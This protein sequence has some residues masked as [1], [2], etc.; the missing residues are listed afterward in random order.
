MNKSRLMLTTLAAVVL[1]I[2]CASAAQ[3]VSFRTHVSLTGNDANTATNC[4]RSNPCRNFAAAYSVTSPAGEIVAL[5]SAGF[6]GLTVTTAVT[7]MAIPG[8][9]GLTQVAAGTSGIAINAGAGDTVILKNLHFGGSLGANTIGVSH[10][11]GKL[12][13]ENCA[14]SQLTTGVQTASANGTSI[15][16][17]TFYG[18][19]NGLLGTVGKIDV[20]DSSFTGHTTRAV[21]ASGTGLITLTEVQVSNNNVGIEA[22][23]FGGCGS[24]NPVQPP[25]TGV[26]VDLGA[27]TN[28]ATAFLM[29]SQ[30]AVC[31][32]AP[33]SHGQNIFMRLVSNTASALTPN[34][35]NN[36]V[37]LNVS[38]VASGNQ[39][40]VGTYN[41]VYFGNQP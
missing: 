15:A 28:N 33:A 9:V 22:S 13:I 18:N 23:G 12:V 17:S 6:G 14:F 31:Q 36:A 20:S 4:S 39:V 3:A 40:V 8:Q 1:T 34:V 27:V 41:S 11:S 30:G 10:N 32:N 2:T 26:W 29:T 35:I 5:D 16:N 21:R 37:T 25:T 19:N 24:T 38:G 7:I